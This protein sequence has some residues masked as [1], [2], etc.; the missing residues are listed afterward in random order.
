M[1]IT[2]IYLIKQSA[3]GSQQS[4]IRQLMDNNKNIKINNLVHSI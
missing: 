2:L 1:L 3:I 4:A